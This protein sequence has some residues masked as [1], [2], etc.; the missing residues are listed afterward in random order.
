MINPIIKI[1]TQQGIS[2]IANFMPGKDEE[3]CQPLFWRVRRKTD[4]TCSKGKEKVTKE[5]KLKRR[6]P[7]STR[8]ITTQA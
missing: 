6:S 7:Y 2:S 3:D 1:I 4:L 5:E 8:G